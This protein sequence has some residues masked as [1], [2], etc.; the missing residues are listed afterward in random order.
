[1]SLKGIYMLI[2]QI[3]FVETIVLML[4]HA[5]QNGQ[6]QNTQNYSRVQEHV[7]HRNLHHDCLNLDVDVDE[8]LACLDLACTTLLE[9]LFKLYQQ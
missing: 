2:F 8:D 5:Y 9:S 4:H 1:M 6:P 3:V 7:L